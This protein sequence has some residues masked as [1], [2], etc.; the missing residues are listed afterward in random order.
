MSRRYRAVLCDLD[1]TLLDTLQDIWRSSER[2]LAALGRPA[3]PIEQ[4]GRYIGKGIPILVHR[5]L[6][7]DLDG[8][9]EPAVFERALA[10]FEDFYA[11]ESGR[12]AVVY[13]KVMEGLRRLRDADVAL[14]CVTNK[15]GRYTSDLLARAGLAQFFSVVVS[16]DTLPVKKP[17]PRPVLH[18]C[19]Q[20]GVAPDEAVVIGDSVNDVQ[21]GRRAGLLVLAVPYGY[22]EG[23]PV[24]SLGAD[25]IVADLTEAAAFL[26]A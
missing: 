2:M 12:N 22:N 21:A 20:L 6:T 4:V 26:G 9:A 5:V 14:A 18:A 11:E 19:A 17:D 23:R 1:G 7:E 16:G 13:P 24:E 10:L 15:A 25:R 8:R 3:M